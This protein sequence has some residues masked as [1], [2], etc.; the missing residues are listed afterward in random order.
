ME[1]RDALL[2]TAGFVA[3][4]ALWGTQFLVI[5]E[6]QVAMPALLAVSLRF[7]LLAVAG[8][9]AARLTKAAAPEGTLVVRALFG[10]AQALSFGLLYVAQRRLDSGLA[11]LLS[12]TTPLFVAVL[13]HVFV[14]GER[15]RLRAAVALLLGFGGSAVLVASS[16][17]WGTPAITLAMA[18]VLV[19]ELAGAANKVLGKGLVTR[20]P[21]TI[22][23]R[24]MG[25]TVA[26]TTGVG[27]LVFEREEPIVLSARAIA[28][29]S[30]LGLVASFGGSA[31]YMRL[32]RI[33]PLTTLGYLQ[34]ATALVASTTGGVIG[35]ERL[36]PS[37]AFGAVAILVGLVLLVWS[38]NHEHRTRDLHTHDT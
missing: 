6:G 28:A 3:L 17:R 22:L 5:R 34:F 30:Y 37:A 4:S 10:L 23:L 1:R 2:A 21:S 14:R 24:D 9:T 12:S 26:L 15:L 7:L 20:V 16:K 31:L 18:F 32:L 33:L 27:W 19:G 8:A 11:G 38:A 35:G 36:A 29:F 13:A 25:A